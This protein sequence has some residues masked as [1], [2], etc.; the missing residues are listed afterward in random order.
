V[1]GQTIFGPAPTVMPGIALYGTAALD[2][3]GI[4]AP[5]LIVGVTHVWRSDLAESSSSASF[6]LDAASVDACP[7]RLGSTQLAARPCASVLAGRLAASGADAPNAAS[8][9]RPFAAAGAAVTA[10]AGIGSRLELAVRLGVGVSLIRDRYEFGS[11]TFYRA[12]PITTSASVG[13][14]ARW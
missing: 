11:T 9:S 4:W 8:F 5:A 12:S 6:T 13:V 7:M 3:D 10:S 2:R 14:G 1:A